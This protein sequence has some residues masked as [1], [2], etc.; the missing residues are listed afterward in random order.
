MEINRKLNLVL[1]LERDDGATWYIHATPISYQ[2]FKDHYFVIAKA[3]SLIYSEGL[4]IA[5]GP[6]IAAMLVRSV[7]KEL[8]IEEKVEQGL[9]AEIKRLANVCK[10]GPQGWETIPL[11]EAIS[12]KLLDER[13]VDEIEGVLCFFTLASSMH[14]KKELPQI[15]STMAGLWGGLIVSSTL[16]EY[17]T[18]LRTSTKDESTGETANLLSIPH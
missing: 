4:H 8:G 15:L 18:S 2:V 13:D 1:P 17:V 12:K 9:M 11:E 7:A 10:P 3:F 5:G 14:L 16:T 6:R